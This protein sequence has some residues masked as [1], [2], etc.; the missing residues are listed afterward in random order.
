[1]GAGIEPTIEESKSSVLPLHHPTI[2]CGILKGKNEK[3][4]NHH[5]RSN[6]YK[7]CQKDEHATYQNVKI[8][9]MFYFVISIIHNS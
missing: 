6:H 2:Y 4:V 3:T 1:M 7:T 9:S 5:Q 8:F